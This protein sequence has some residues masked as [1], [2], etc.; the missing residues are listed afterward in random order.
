MAPRDGYMPYISY[1]LCLLEGMMK[2]SKV[3]LNLG[4]LASNFPDVH[5]VVKIP[6]VSEPTVC[7]FEFW[8]G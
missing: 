4:G 3:V 8:K 5:A 6:V 7:E 2:L 1:A